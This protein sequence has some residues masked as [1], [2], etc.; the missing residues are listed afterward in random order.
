[1]SKSSLPPYR[2]HS[3]SMVGMPAGLVASADFNEFPMPLRVSGTREANRS[4]FQ[5]L[6]AAADVTEASTIFQDYMEVIFGF[7]SEQ[8]QGTDSHGRRRFRSSYLRLLNGWGF[9]SNSQEGAVLKGWVES[10]FGLFPTYHK[11]PIDRFNSPAWITYVEEKMS[12]RF[13]NNSINMQLDL[14]YEFCQWAM[15]RFHAR[16]RGHLTLYRGTN[17]FAE[18]PMVERRDK[19]NVVIRLNNLVSF[20]ANRELA[21]EFG[22]FIMEARVP[23]V[24]ILFFNELLP[25]HSLK[26]ESEYLVIG[27][28]YLVKVSTL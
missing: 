1:M 20:S 15:V 27:G 2:G 9:D 3:T 28:D 18:H 17:G 26:G 19:S 13:H 8:R 6:D 25:F 11:G 21:S 12:S 16:G 7:D 24:K 23:R 10:R 4:L 22:D 14:L 5:R